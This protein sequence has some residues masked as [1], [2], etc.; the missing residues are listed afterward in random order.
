MLVL[1][2]CS[3]VT[4]LVGY[5]VHTVYMKYLYT[6]MISTWVRATLYISID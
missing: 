3:C 5:G 6:L 2:L 1:I 4:T